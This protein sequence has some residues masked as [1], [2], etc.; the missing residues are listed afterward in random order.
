MEK[1]LPLKRIL[2]LP[3]L[4]RKCTVF[5]LKPF[6]FVNFL[7]KHPV[8]VRKH[9]SAASFFCGQAAILFEVDILTDN[10]Q[11]CHKTR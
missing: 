3:V 6:T 4:D 2:A 7:T 1:L 9:L 8:V 11:E 10:R 5:E